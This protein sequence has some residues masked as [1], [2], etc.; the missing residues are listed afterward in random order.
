MVAGTP[1]YLH[2]DKQNLLFAKTNNLQVKT[3]E[4]IKEVGL[5]MSLFKRWLRQAGSD[6]PIVKAWQ[7]LI[8]LPYDKTMHAAFKGLFPRML[9]LTPEQ[10]EHLFVLCSS[11]DTITYAKKLTLLLENATQLKAMF[12]AHEGGHNPSSDLYLL[13]L[14]GDKFTEVKAFIDAYKEQ[15]PQF[16][17]HLLYQLL[18]D[19][20][21]LRTELAAVYRQIPDLNLNAVVQLYIQSGE[22]GVARLMA[23]ATHEEYRAEFQQLNTLIFRHGTSY[24]PVLTDCDRIYSAIKGYTEVERQ[25][26]D[27]LVKQHMQAHS[28][29]NVH[30]LF[31]AFNSFLAKLRDLSSGGD[32]ALTLPACELEGVKSL[33]VTLSRIIAV[34]ERC[35]NEN[36][37]PQLQE[38]GRLDWSSRGAIKPIFS[39]THAFVTHE[40][41]I[42]PEQ[43][44][45][46]YPNAYLY[47]SPKEDNSDVGLKPL[48]HQRPRD[49]N[50]I[51]KYFFRYVATGKDRDDRQALLGFYQF[52]QQQIEASELPENVRDELYVLFARVT[53]GSNKPKA[54]SSLEEGKKLIDDVIEALKN[55]TVPTG[56]GSYRAQ[57]QFTIINNLTELNVLPNLVIANNLLKMIYSKFS[58]S[59]LITIKSKLQAFV[60]V[61]AQLHEL[62]EVNGNPVY[63]GMK[64]YNQTDYEHED[65]FFNHVAILNDIKDVFNEDYLDVSCHLMALISTFRL[66]TN[67]I[68]TLKTNGELKSLFTTRESKLALALLRFA[69]QSKQHVLTEQDLIFILQKVAQETYTDN[70]NNDNIKTQLAQTLKNLTLAQGQPLAIYFPEHFLDSYGKQKDSSDVLN[71]STFQSQQKEQI[72]LILEHFI[73]PNDNDFYPQIMAELERICQPLTTSD[74]NNFISKLSATTGLYVQEASD[75]VMIEDFL[76]LLRTINSPDDL[77]NF[78]VSEKI[79][80]KKLKSTQNYIPNL[81]LKSLLYLRD[82]LPVFKAGEITHLSLLELESRLQEALLRTPATECTAAGYVRKFIAAFQEVKTLIE[83]HVQAKGPLLA[84]FDRYLNNYSAEKSSLCDYLNRFNGILS[85]AFAGFAGD[86]KNIILRL[87]VRFNDE[88]DPNLTPEKLLELLQVINENQGNKNLL[89]KILAYEKPA[90]DVQFTALCTKLQE[91]SFAPVLKQHIYR[92]APFPSISTL[93]QW[94]EEAKQEPDSYSAKMVALHR[95]FQLNPCHREP[96]SQF[97]TNKAEQQLAQFKGFNPQNCN[98]AA[99]AAAIEKVKGGTNSSLLNTLKLLKIKK[100]QLIIIP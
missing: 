98:T 85:A 80:L 70:N 97:N 49:L 27:V 58:K 81:S 37:Y 52:V 93:L 96:E 11:E 16:S 63:E 51:K 72:K 89:L 38:A 79:V 68:N 21:E 82:I 13:K 18:A 32:R 88:T 66:S 44:I 31:N 92:N 54:I 40:M 9:L 64:N 69:S 74:K 47:K 76:Q 65:L 95:D 4:P 55:I 60:K 30:D 3:E 59:S 43:E 20:S 14:F 83:Q 41:F 19:N 25:W 1:K 28:H 77:I 61:F 7:Q 22:Q 75:R 73:G 67:F 15:A 17:E 10:Q 42:I 24:L 50:N 62:T 87:C 2:F 86:N 56:L 100:S 57:I 78:S 90:D 36:R 71:N 33:P 46:Q 84:S 23:Q 26:W 53:V 99:F 5:P 8:V 35:K 48:L 91:A 45:T 94:H 29:A 6:H 12:Q 34:L 39:G